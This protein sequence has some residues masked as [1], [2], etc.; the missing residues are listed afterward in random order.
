MFFK[1]ESKTC[2]T[3]MECY[4]LLGTGQVQLITGWD[5]G[6]VCVIRH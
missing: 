4:D 1:F 2:A 5:N 6:K 3:A